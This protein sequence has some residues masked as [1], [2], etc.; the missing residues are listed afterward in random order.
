MAWSNP[1]RGWPELSRS[2]DFPVKERRGATTF[3]LFWEDGSWKIRDQQ[4]EILLGLFEPGIAV[5][6]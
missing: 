6:S 3:E 4:G 2:K 1:D 5:S